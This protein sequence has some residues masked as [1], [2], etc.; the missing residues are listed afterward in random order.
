M[1]LK[2][3]FWNGI[4]PEN[5]TLRLVLGTCPTIAIS[6]AAINGLG[7]GLAATFVLVGSNVMVSLLRNFIPSKARI[8]AFV[9]IIAT[10]VTIVDLL[11][12]AYSPALYSALGIFIPLIVVN[13]IILAR[14]EAFA[15]QNGVMASLMDGV[16]MGLGFTLALTFISAVREILGSGTLFGLSLFGA[17]FQPI[18]MFAQSP[19]GFIV[20]GLT[21]GAANAIISRRTRKKEANA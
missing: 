19:G 8:P 2:K 6:K 11:I 13:C 7:M 1:K 5:P 15:S 3:V 16:G 14:A 9:V 21:I 20:F 4:I 18:A 12:K 17:N 10:F